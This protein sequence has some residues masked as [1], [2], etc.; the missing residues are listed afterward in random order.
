MVDVTLSD[1][2]HN[3]EETCYN[4]LSVHL[5]HRFW[6]AIEDEKLAPIVRFDCGCSTKLTY[7]AL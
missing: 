3:R 2:C 1:V 5:N 6:I 7:C 4:S